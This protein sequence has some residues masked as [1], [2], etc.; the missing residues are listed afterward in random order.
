MNQNRAPLWEAIVKYRELNPAVFHV[1]GH[2]QGRAVPEPMLN[3]AGQ[4]FFSI[5]LTEVP[6]LDDLHNP[7]GAIARAQALAAELYGADRTYFSVNGTSGGLMALIMAV[8]RTGE[9]ICV[10]RNMHRSVLSGLIWSGADPVYLPPAVIEPFG[11]AAGVAPGSLQSALADCAAV[12]GVL[13]VHPSYYGVT[14]NLS[15]LAALAH[16]H[17]VPLLVDEAHGAHLHFHRQLPVDALS[18]GADGVAQSTHK[19][20]GALTQASMVHIQGSRLNRGRL[21]AAMSMVQST[22]PSY[23]LMAS[24]DLA[25]QQLAVKGRDLLQ[26]ALELA[27]ETRQGITELPG[28]VLLGQEHLGGGG[29]SALDPTRLTVNVTGLGL[30]GYQAAEYLRQR[31]GVQ[32]EM[33]DQR[34]IVAVISIGTG[35]ADC[36]RL[37]AGLSGLVRDNRPGTGLISSAPVKLPVPE[38]ILT[39]RQAWLADSQAVPL[40]QARDRI[41]AETVAAYPPGIPAICPGEA[42]TAEVQEYLIYLRRCRIPVQGPADAALN[43][44]QVLQN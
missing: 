20:A 8:C 41:S 12:K 1:P 40:E 18:C 27:W 36:S 24:L 2:R 17:G 37:L 4:D 26:R 31:Q 3:L 30:N 6:G 32:V 9:K 42:V 7:Q 39:P 43:T 33:A 38:K 15:G 29:A 44:L 23:I 28:L 10:P 19:L 35:P 25:R 22:S 5:D 34:N 13:A 21:T 14:G 11:V 16:R